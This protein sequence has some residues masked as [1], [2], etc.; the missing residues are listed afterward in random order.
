MKNALIAGIIRNDCIFEKPFLDFLQSETRELNKSRQQ[1]IMA[2]AAVLTFQEPLVVIILAAWAYLVIAVMGEPFSS[3]I[4]RSKIGPL[5]KPSAMPLGLISEHFPRLARNSRG[6]E[7]SFRNRSA[8]T[9][10]ANIAELA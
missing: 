2:T 5:S 3:V 10:A 7:A 4:V 9:D 6:E 1:Q 8:R